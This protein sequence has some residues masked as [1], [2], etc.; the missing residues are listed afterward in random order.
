MPFRSADD[1]QNG[2]GEQ[3]RNND[4]IGQLYGFGAREELQIAAGV[5]QSSID[6]LRVH[7]QRLEECLG[8]RADQ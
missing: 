5:D 1:Y 2:D 3:Y 4:G 8:P 7:G 6:F